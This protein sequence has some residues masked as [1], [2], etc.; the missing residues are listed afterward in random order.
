MAG[1]FWGL[2]PGHSQL[3]KIIP[4]IQ[5]LEEHHRLHTFREEYIAFLQK[6]EVDYRIEYL[7]QEVN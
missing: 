1:G 3:S 7:F 5:N 2:Y 4:Y 6:Y